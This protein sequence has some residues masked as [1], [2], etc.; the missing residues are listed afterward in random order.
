MKLHDCK[1]ELH[2]AGSR[3]TPGRLALLAV[4]EREQTPLSVPRLQKKLPCL[5]QVTL[6]RALD[7]LAA[8]GLI[9]KGV[10]ADRTAHYEYAGRPH[11]HHLVC[12][13]CGF[14]KTCATC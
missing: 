6:Y 12:T 1:Q 11:H 7:A 14:A 3:A 10:G 13:D 5:N 2:Q 9:R 8:A 4:L